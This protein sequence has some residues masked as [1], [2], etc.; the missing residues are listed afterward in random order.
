M[1]SRS[2]VWVRLRGETLDST[3]YTSLAR[4]VWFS[5]VWFG[6]VWFSLARHASLCSMGSVNHSECNETKTNNWFQYI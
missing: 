2:S 1:L 5:L 3:V 6:L 4:L